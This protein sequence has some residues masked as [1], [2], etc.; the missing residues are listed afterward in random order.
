IERLQRIQELFPG[1]EERNEELQRLYLAV[2]LTPK[3]AEPPPPP[4]P[5][6]REAPAP[7]PAEGTDI[8]SFTRAA[9]ITQ[10]L[11]R[12]T[13][14]DAVLATV[15]TEIGTQWK[16][17]RCVAALRKPGLAA[18]SLK[19]H[20]AE[21]IQDA[22]PKLLAKLLATA[23]ELAIRNG[24][25]T[26][27]DATTTT[28][29]EPVRDAVNALGIRSLVALTLNEG[30]HQMGVLLLMRSTAQAWHA[31]DVVVLKTL[32]DQIVMAMNNAGLRRLVK[33][34]S[35]TDE[36]SGLMKR[37]SYLD[38]LLG[39]TQRA[40]Q[41]H[42]PLT[43]VLMQF[44]D[45]SAMVKEFGEA[46]VEASMQQIGQLC[47]TNIRQNDLAFR[48]EMTTIALVLGDSDSDDA[49]L[50]VEKLRKLLEQVPQPGRDEAIR[51]HAGVAEACIRQS[52]D[53]VDIVTEVINR[54][55]QAL[56]EALS[57]GSGK[58]VSL[59]PAIASAAVA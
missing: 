47:S 27:T 45:R 10:K 33:N 8:S 5:A 56:E 53:P 54:G 43:V 44:G 3:R 36:H 20:C 37:A 22:E 49:I 1:E 17:G 41:H 4:A 28:E 52:F 7:R 35:V 13:N 50:A 19:Q 55:E 48:Y 12:Q 29:L 42:N 9:E 26:T 6:P 16:A 25:F 38:L 15:V 31:N 23:Q 11:Y 40:V 57:Q 46:A 21:G 58:V 34:L 18:T 39:E 59:S 51:F 2:G 30:P 32:S 14:A 24:S